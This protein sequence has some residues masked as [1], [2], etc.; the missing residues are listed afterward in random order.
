MSGKPLSHACYGYRQ[1]ENDK[2]LWEIDEEAAN[3]VK[4]IFQLCINGYGPSQI[5]RMLTENGVPMP[6]EYALL[7]GKVP[8]HKNVKRHNK[9]DHQTVAFILEKA[10]YAGHTVNFRAENK[11]YKNRQQKN[12]Q[13]DDWV[14]FENTHEPIVSQHDFDL[15]QELRKNKRRPQKC[16][17]INPFSGMVYCADCGFKMY[18]C[19]SASLTGKQEHLKCSTYAKDKNEC[20]AHFIRTEV[21]RTIVIS[22]LNKLLETVHTNED[23]FI[24]AAMEN[25]VQSQESELKKARKLVKQYE[26]RVSALDKLFTRLTAGNMTKKERLRRVSTQPFK[27]NRITSVP[28]PTFS[29]DGFYIRFVIS[30]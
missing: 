6:S 12:H 17:E 26:K 7:Q 21:L 20:S 27:F 10:E 25:S 28:P 18:L 14:I 4:E 8:N 23:E 1:S 13:K 19:R 22:E 15:V 9:W 30:I 3:V 2:N 5:A 16:D 29:A 24:R 11:S